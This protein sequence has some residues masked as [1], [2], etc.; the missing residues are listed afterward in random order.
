[1]YLRRINHKQAD[2]VKRDYWVLLESYRTERGPRQRI[3]SYLGESDSAGRL[4][5]KQAA[6]GKDYYQGNLFNEEDKPEWIEIDIRK[7]RTERSLRFGDIFLAE[8][9]IKRLQLDKLLEEL[10]GE[11]EESG[12]GRK[13]EIP[14]NI[15]AELLIISRFCQ[16]SS[17]L[18]IA[19]E[20]IKESAICDLLGISE[21]KIY[22]NRLY[23]GLDKLIEKKEE[24]QQSMKQRLGELFEIKYDILLY[25][26]TSTYFEGSAEENPKAQ[27]GYSRDSRGDCKQVCIGLVV[28]KEGIPIGYEVF[29]GNRHDS[30][31]V[32]EIIELMEKRYGKSQRVWI[33]DR[34][35]ISRKNLEILRAEG[36]RYI[37]GTPKNQLKKFEQ[38]LLKEDWENV[39]EGLEVKL[40]REEESDSGEVFILCR[41]RMRKE[42]D[43]AIT[44]RFIKRIEDG[45]AKCQ[46]Q[47]KEGKIKNQNILERRIGRLLER[48][49]RA[50]GLFEI[51]IDLKEKKLEL[52]WEMKKSRK[53]FS[54]ISQGCYL[55]RSN[56][57]N[58]TGEELW[59]AYIQLTDAE[60]AFKIHKN[61]LQLRPVFHQ[62]QQRVEAHILVCFLSYVLW[63]TLSQMCKRA[64]L[65]NE[66][67][68]IVQEMKRI[69]L[70]D[71][72][73]PTR[74]GSQIRLRCVTQPDRQLSVLLEHLKIRIPQRWSNN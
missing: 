26:V 40:C 24:L 39:Y 20:F 6:E 54:E 45:L 48:N 73:L 14:Y 31:T 30:K 2:G 71:V 70:S 12:S 67:R 13:A 55:L 53:E 21:D 49:Q 33:M 41:S 29:E 62:K 37:I 16:P 52:H 66:P 63:K 60:E 42:K 19:E 47:C 46:K 59:R 68:K 64:G 57:T 27:R 72:V 35:M 18:Y 5:M 50:S 51:I 4:G 74:N 11:S 61:D 15:L 28:T 25:D 58:W 44:E 9:L 17:E 3:V 34:G 7:V 22:D 56:I 69:I 8:E 65:G 23:R 32:E 1:M 43:K 38:E 10:L 36:R